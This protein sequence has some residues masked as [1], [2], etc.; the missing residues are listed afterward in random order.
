MDVDSCSRCP[1][2][3]EC[4]TQIVNGVGDTDANLMFVG[5]APGENEDEQGK[6]FVG[7]SGTVLD[8]ALKENGLSRVDVRITN[9]ARC[10]PPENRDPTEEELENCRD[11]LLNEIRTVDPAVVV[12]LGKVP[13]EHL[14]DRPVPV[15]KEVGTTVE[16]RLAGEPRTV[17]ICVH[18]AATLY[19]SSQ[20]DA[21][22]Q[23]IETAV[24]DSGTDGGQSRLGDF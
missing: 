17:V 12:A 6:P 7:R 16:T 2:L 23:T 14:L 18:P 10:R 13:S 19:D 20:K 8:S 21:F 22:A 24:A 3:E 1:Q 5:E 9:C 15:T 4:R 11:H